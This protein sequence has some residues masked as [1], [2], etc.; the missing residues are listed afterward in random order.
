[1]LHRRRFKQTTPP[2]ERLSAFITAMQER[3]VPQPEP[4]PKAEAACDLGAGD[5]RKRER[6]FAAPNKRLNSLLIRK[7][8]ED[9]RV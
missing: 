2:K 6:R 8:N 3:A 4:S 9:T 1:M 5:T 7:Q